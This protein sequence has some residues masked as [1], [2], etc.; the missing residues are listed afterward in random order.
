MTRVSSHLLSRW[1]GRFGSIEVIVFEGCRPSLNTVMQDIRDEAKLWCTVGAKGGSLAYD[2]DCMGVRS[3]LI[4]LLGISVARSCTYRGYKSC[5]NYR[6]PY[7]PRL[8]GGTRDGLLR[9]SPNA[10]VTRP[11]PLSRA[12]LGLDPW[13]ARLARARHVKGVGP[14]RPVSTVTL[15]ARQ[16]R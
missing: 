1:H 4:F 15:L 7:G 14:L 5:L 13:H 2:L 10:L 3:F 16:A 8:N 6:C 12:V 9:P 11:G